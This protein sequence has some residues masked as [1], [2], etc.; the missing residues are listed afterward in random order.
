MMREA[1]SS[2]RNVLK[3]R[4]I[5]TAYLSADRPLSEVI[6]PQQGTAAGS[7]HAAC[8]CTK[9]SIAAAIILCPFALG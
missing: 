4:I 2:F 6:Y 7:S 9:F 1:L 5:K 8:T 3:S